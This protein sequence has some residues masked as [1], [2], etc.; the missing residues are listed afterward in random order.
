MYRAIVSLSAAT[1]LALSAASSSWA[2]EQP[3][4]NLD[5]T[6]GSFALVVGY[7][8]GSGTL[9]YK[10]MDYRFTAN[11]VSFGDVGA[12]GGGATG[13]VYHL[14]R[15]EDFPGSYTAFAAGASLGFGA[16]GAT[17]RNQN[18][19]VIH[20]GALGGGV[21]ATLAPMGVSITLEGPAAPTTGS[22]R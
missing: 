4:A 6:G 14:S 1:L 15:I 2:E 5:F 12:S 20:V 19:V 9:H 18:G 3:D 7:H 8:G 17:M 13:N 10:G 21:Q 22:S 16:G 11:G